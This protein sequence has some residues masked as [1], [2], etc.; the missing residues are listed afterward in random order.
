[1]KKTIFGLL[2][3]VLLG[4]G[5]FFY[6]R[7]DILMDAVPALFASHHKQVIQERAQ[8]LF[9][10]LRRGEVEACVPLTD[11]DL[12]HRSGEDAARQ[13]YKIM[14]GLVKAGQFIGGQ[15][16]EDFRVDTI[17]LSSDG[18]TATVSASIRAG[19]QWHKLDAYR[20]VRAGNQWYITF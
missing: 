5:G 3:L 4:A 14:S 13:R 15:G 9:N 8:A 18:K 7:P 16:E 20:W 10:H 6:L 1:M 11:P 2:L 12:L 17:D 19:G